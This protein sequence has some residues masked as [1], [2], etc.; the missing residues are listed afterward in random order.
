MLTRLT[1]RSRQI[2]SGENDTIMITNDLGQVSMPSL[3]IGLQSQASPQSS[4]AKRG[5]L[6]STKFL[7]VLLLTIALVVLAPQNLR[8]QA[9]VSTGGIE[10]VVTDINGGVVPNAQVTITHESTGQVINGK[11]TVKG[12][13]TGGLLI[14]GQYTV[15]IEAAGFKTV[16]RS[17]R[18][19]VGTITPVDLKLGVGERVEVVEVTASQIQV[20]TDQN[21]VKGV[22]SAQQIEDL[23]INGRNFLDLAQLEPGVQIQDGTNFDPTKIGYSSISFAG[24]FGRSARIE[25]DGIDISDETV[26]TATQDIP[27]TAIQEFQL[28]QSS[29]DLSTELTSSGAVNV[30]TRSGGNLLHGEGFGLFRDSTVA[31]A[32]P[33]GTGLKPPFQRNQFGGRFGGPAIKDKLFFFASAEH[34]K[35]DLQAPVALPA[36]F[37]SF[38]GTYSAPFRETATLGRI[39]Y[40]ITNAAHLFYRYT[41]FDSLAKSTFFPSSFQVY[42]SKNYSRDHAIGFD[43]TNGNFAHSLRFSYLNFQNNISDATRGTGLPLADF[44]VSLVIGNLQTGPNLLAPQF[45]L[46]N[47]RQFKYDGVRAFSTHT[48]SFGVDY[49]RI[50]DVGNAAFFGT[51]PQATIGL[52]AN[53]I[54]FANNSCGAGQPCFPGGSSNPLNYP[55]EQVLLGT[56]QG[57]VSEKPA[58]GRPAGGLGPDHR[59]GLYLG[60]KWRV[61]PNLTLTYGVRYVRDTGRSDSDLGPIPLLN[62]LAPGLGDRIH[63]PNLD[64]APQLGFAYAPWRDNKTVIRAGMGLFYDNAVFNNLYGDR[65]F[66]LQSG[67][68]LVAVPACVGPGL[69]VPVPTGSQTL[70]P[71]FCGPSSGVA[72]GQVAQQIANLQNQLQSLTPFSLTAANPNFVGNLVSQGINLSANVPGAQMLGPNYQTP[73]AVQFNIGVEREIRKGMV[74][75]VDYV[76]NVATHFLLGVD[77]NHVGDVKHFNKAAAISAISA[78]NQ[79]LG[80]GS[81]TDAASIN[82]AINNGAQISSYAANGLGSPGLDFGGACPI[83][84]GCAFSGIN[85]AFPQVVMANSIGRSVYNALQAKLVQEMKKPLPGISNINL[86]LSYSLSRFVSPGAG[87]FQTPAQSDLDLVNNA[88]DNSKPLRYMGPNL[89]D[90][91]HQVSLGA[92]VDLAYGF[93]T[94]IVSHFYSPLATALVVPNTGLG[95]GEIFRTDF[96]GDGTVGDLVPGT[97]LGSFG[98]STSASNL[99]SL[100]TNYNSTQANQPTPAGQT[101]ISNGLFTLA[102][103]QSL[104]GVAPAIP[105]APAGQVNTAWLRAFDLKLAWNHPVRERVLIAPSVS[106]YNLF[107][108]ANF[109]L[110][111]GVMSPLLNGSPGSVNGTTAKDRISNRVGVGTGVFGLG[112]PR[113]LEFGLRVEF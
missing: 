15:R 44:P 103:L 2:K 64:F 58:L 59:L 83:A 99:N 34:N 39:D 92:T 84:G 75:S 71:T 62:S 76:R 60:D 102:Q 98:R 14:P 111:P 12:T 95:A 21:S 17:I 80:C 69:P 87:T 19:Q 51:S 68:F 24:R 56:G 91:T 36:P 3:G 42:S 41:Y 85:P 33:S 20:I 52:T 30:I 101:L 112:S 73:R 67:S 28:S 100:I 37:S 46:Q 79:S 109:D 32:L 43:F 57:F 29:L 72:V 50:Q 31:A 70:Q 93:T 45:T 27:A 49:N 25:V 8:A 53:E 55:V 40:Q 22:L 82:C 105:L 96:T 9:T 74:L 10:A 35:Q 11:T 86:Q 65:P 23:P 107:N 90:R 78:T 113:V 97:K 77:Q 4:L 106:V 89:L 94:S 48:L 104:G 1:L 26:G 110:P 108:F 6:A 88:L 5:R 63:H 47:N 81:G 66:R 18:V 38:S 61:R 7:I 13:F 16:E 54:N